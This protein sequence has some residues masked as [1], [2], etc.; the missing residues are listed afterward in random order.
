MTET[1]YPVAL[2]NG[3]S[4]AELL[5]ALHNRLDDT[6]Y[7]HCLRVEDTAR[8]LAERFGADVARA[9]LAGLFHDYGK[10]IPV[11]DYTDV[12]K[13]NGFDPALLDYGRGVWHGLV[14]TWFIE[15]EVGLTDQ[16]ILQAIARHTTGDPDMTLL[17]EIIFVADYI[18]PARDLPEEAKARQA[19]ETSMTE[20]TR[21][22]L[23]NS[24]TYLIG[25][26][27]RVFPQTLLT[28]NAFL[29]KE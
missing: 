17:D 26:R 15:T 1:E 10:Q 2:T 28:Y 7:A 6:R 12:I 29:T 23:E 3:R 5:A 22:E 9:G 19:A 18:E 8:H 20:A 13:H 25:E 21:I 16:L 14:G 4:R 27:K 24:L 11:K